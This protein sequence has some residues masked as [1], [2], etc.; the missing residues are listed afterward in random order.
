MGP[1]PSRTARR[2]VAV[3]PQRRPQ[4]TTFMRASCRRTV[5][6]CAI[7]RGKQTVGVVVEVGI[8]DQPNKQGPIAHVH[9]GAF[10]VAAVPGLRLQ[11]KADGPGLA[12]QDSGIERRFSVILHRLA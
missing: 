7:S 8:A 9:L 5:R 2:P 1:W 11:V 3:L 4:A 10:D 6:W 12:A